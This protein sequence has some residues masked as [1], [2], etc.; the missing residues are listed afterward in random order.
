MPVP[1]YSPLWTVSD[2]KELGISD[3]LFQCLVH[4]RCLK[5]FYFLIFRQYKLTSLL[6]FPG[7]TYRV[8]CVKFTQTENQ[9]FTQA[10]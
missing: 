5:K 8:M 3:Q 2:V 10:S 1:T 4:T 9:K 7:L 6:I